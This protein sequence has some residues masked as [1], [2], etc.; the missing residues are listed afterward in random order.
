MISYQDQRKINAQSYSM[1]IPEMARR[2]TSYWICSVPSKMRRVLPTSPGSIALWRY[3]MSRN[4]FG[5]LSA[6]SFHPVPPITRDKTRDTSL[7]LCR[8]LLASGRAVHE[9]PN[10]RTAR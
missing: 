3:L 8:Q 5:L 6:S 10:Q 9:G 7:Q 2:I 4:D 1:R